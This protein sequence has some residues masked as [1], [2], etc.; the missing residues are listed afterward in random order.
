MEKKIRFIEHQEMVA[1]NLGDTIKVYANVDEYRLQVVGQIT[2]SQEG[3]FLFSQEQGL[4]LHSYDLKI[5]SEFIVEL[6]KK[7]Q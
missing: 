5:I 3:E 6:E 4:K 7:E 2:K 1:I